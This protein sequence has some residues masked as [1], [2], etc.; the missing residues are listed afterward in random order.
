LRDDEIAGAE[1]DALNWA[2]ERGSRSG[3]VAWQFA[4][5]WAGSAASKRRQKEHVRQPERCDRVSPATARK[6]SGSA[7][8][9]CRQPARRIQG[10][11]TR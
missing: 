10:A 8:V 9:S 3:R 2:L 11:I 6:R 4:R 5:D 1:R 7:I